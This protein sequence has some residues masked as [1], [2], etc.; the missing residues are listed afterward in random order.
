MT[1]KEMRELLT[2]VRDAKYPSKLDR[3]GARLTALETVTLK[4]LDWLETANRNTNDE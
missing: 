4:L 1:L 3:N 2:S